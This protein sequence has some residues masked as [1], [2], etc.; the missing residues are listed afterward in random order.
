LSSKKESPASLAA[1]LIPRL[2][3]G[4]EF[5]SRWIRQEFRVPRDTVRQALLIAGQDI[6]D[7]HN[8]VLVKA[9]FENGYA[10]RVTD[11]HFE[12]LAGEAQIMQASITSVSRSVDR[13][14]RVAI[15]MPP[16][17]YRNTAERQIRFVEKQW[18]LTRELIEDHI[19]WIKD[20]KK[21]NV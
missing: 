9:H 21:E 4:E 10:I 2:L 16:G 14:Q 20:M 1:V 19:E 12:A 5:T 15:L 7:L 6:W 11:D 3:D 13:Q 17:I 8:R 18:A